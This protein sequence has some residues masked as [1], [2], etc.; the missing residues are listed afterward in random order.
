MMNNFKFFVEGDEY[1]KDV[2]HS[3]LIE[4]QF[5]QKMKNNKFKLKVCGLSKL[6]NNILVFFPKG[7]NVNIPEESNIKNAKTLFQ[8]IRK[9]K[10]TIRL[11][12]DEYDWLGK[13]NELI[14][15][16]A[17]VD[18]LIDDFKRN[19]FYIEK[20][21]KRNINQGSRIDWSRTI[22]NQVPF[23]KDEQLIYLDVITKKNHINANDVITIIHQM[24][25][26]E[27]EK[28]YGWL[29]SFDYQID[30]IEIPFDTETQIMILE[31]KLDET[32]TNR[33]IKLIK[34]M[35][36]FIKNSNNS[37]DVY[38]LV[39]P[40][41][42]SIWEVI[43]KVIFKHDENIQDKF[44]K[45]YWQ[46]PNENV[47]NSVQI[48][49]ILIEKNSELVIIDAKYYAISSGNVSK[50]P[51][52][53]SIVKQLYYNLS[54]EHIYDDIQNIFIMPKSLEKNYEYIGKASVKEKESNFGFVYAYAID[55]ELVMNAYLVNNYLE[56]VLNSIIESYKRQ[57]NSFV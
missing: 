48:P 19:G 52:W 39:T 37:E 25:L 42:Y 51:G 11:T 40:Y 5:F 54:V 24:I 32:Y 47:K 31:K 15:N 44:P 21:E 36:A 53:E 4:L 26:R 34:F 8:V 16:I 57:R 41:F 28:Q 13:E 14:N 33:H 46:L 9:Y 23:I 27:C 56:D 3:Q 38:N 20:I 17:I 7:Y 29:F 18:W 30:P 55:I 6:D 50:F 2:V 35:I 43:L 10:D 12:E 22:K 49:D 1:E 45:P